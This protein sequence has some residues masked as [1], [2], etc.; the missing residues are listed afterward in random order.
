MD[1]FGKEGL[2]ERPGK[3]I[4]TKASIY[5]KRLK[6]VRIL[7]AEDNPTNQEIAKAILEGA[8]I[9]VEIV[10]NGEAAVEAAKK[11]RFDAVLMDIQMPKMDGY[12]A[13]ANIRKIP[14]LKSLPIIAMTAHAMKGDEEKCLEAGMDAYISKPINQDRLFQAIWKLIESGKGLPDDKKAATVVS[15]EAVDTP[16]IATRALPAKLPG[17]NIQDAL[18]A[19]NIGSDVFKRILIGFLRNNKDVPNN[20]KDVFDRNDWE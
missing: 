17:I 12:E 8:G 15:E 5:K 9:I 11:G 20:I 13:T 4:T 6:G 18:E 14:E 3:E 16:V 10:E 2:G 19:L 7:V 1:L